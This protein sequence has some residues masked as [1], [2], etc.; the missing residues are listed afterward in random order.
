MARDVPKDYH[1][2][3]TQRKEERL[4]TVEVSLRMWR[5]RCQTFLTTLHLSSK[6]TVT[7]DV[8]FVLIDTEAGVYIGV[9]EGHLSY[10]KSAGNVTMNAN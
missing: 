1:N 5:W 6:D 2:G 7:A 10:N 3:D 4:G 9:E 8:I